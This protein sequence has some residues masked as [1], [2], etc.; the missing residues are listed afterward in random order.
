MLFQEG[1]SAQAYLSRL[2]PF[3]WA[4][5]PPLNVLVWSQTSPHLPLN[6][7]V[8]LILMNLLR[9]FE[10][11]LK[12]HRH[13]QGILPWAE[14]LSLG[15]QVSALFLASILHRRDKAGHRYTSSGFHLPLT[16]YLA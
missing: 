2:W 6:L 1:Y 8:P 11:P 5:L 15:L 7:A 13:I 14:A 10:L 3:F 16:M 4:H 12:Q 9:S